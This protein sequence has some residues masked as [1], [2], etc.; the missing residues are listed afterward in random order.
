[1]FYLFILEKQRVKACK[2][3]QDTEG[4]GERE[5]EADSAEHRTQRRAQSHD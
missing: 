1:M 4:E 2:Q 3:G 5:P